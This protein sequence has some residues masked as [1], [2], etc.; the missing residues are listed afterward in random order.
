MQEN[1]HDSEFYA[2]AHWN[3][4]GGVFP[5]LCRVRAFSIRHEQDLPNSRS[6][7][8]DDLRAMS[9]LLRSAKTCR[10]NNLMRG[11]LP[12]GH[13]H[14]ATLWFTN[15]LEFLSWFLP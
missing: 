15:I 1:K 11:A 14:N 9:M 4:I 10:Q 13:P 6:P 2:N 3:L 5:M 7:S 12:L 8:L